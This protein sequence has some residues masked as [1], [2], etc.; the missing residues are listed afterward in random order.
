MDLYKISHLRRRVGDRRS[1]KLYQLNAGGLC[2][3][4]F[5]KF[6]TVMAAMAYIAV[7]AQI[8]PLFSPSGVNVHPCLIMVSWA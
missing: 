7:A 4:K 3:L 2:G 6:A 8:D 1:S 5:E